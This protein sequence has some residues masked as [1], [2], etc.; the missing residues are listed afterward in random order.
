MGVLLASDAP[1]ENPTTKTTMT[2]AGSGVPGSIAPVPKRHC[3]Y[4][5]TQSRHTIGR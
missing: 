3:R 5:R 2:D 4:Q 1:R